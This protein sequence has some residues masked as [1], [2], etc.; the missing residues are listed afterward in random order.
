[1]KKFAVGLLLL[2][3]CKSAPTPP[4]KPSLAERLGGTYA[5]A[6]VCQDF[7][8]RLL[9]NRVITAN[10]VVA[11]NADPARVPGLWF[12]LTAQIIDATGGPYKYHGR[13]MKDVHHGL[14]ITEAEWNAMVTDL[15]ATL[16]AFKVPEAEQGEL[17]EILG[18]TKKDIVTAP[19]TDKPTRPS[20]QGNSLYARLGGAYPITAVCQDLLGRL[21]ANKTVMANP[22]VA[23]RVKPER[24]PG[25][26]FHLTAQLIEATG[27][28]MRYAGK[29]MKEAHAGMDI[30]G[31]EW[32]AMAADFKACLDHFKVPARE[33]D[34]LFKIVGTLKADIVKP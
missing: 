20:V 31:K 9:Q 12:H 33:Q 26:L 16:A 23:E 34:E 21:I 11:Q 3:A 25:L 4:P 1:M 30:T 17:L 27:G 13:T 19:T 14:N 7:L 15:K 5:I 10:K 2:A 28:P 22:K 8:G 24:G 32:D 6:A 18:T 29:P